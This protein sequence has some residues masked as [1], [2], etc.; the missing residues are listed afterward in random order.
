[1]EALARWEKEDGS[2]LLPNYFISLSEKIRL[3]QDI[4]ELVFIDVCKK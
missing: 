2:I 4:D 1:M 3:I